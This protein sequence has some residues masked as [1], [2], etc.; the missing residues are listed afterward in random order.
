MEKATAK[1]NVI[2]LKKIRS[3]LA[4]TRKTAEKAL[5][6]AKRVEHATLLA[7]KQIS[8]LKQKAC[9]EV[10]K[11]EAKLATAE[12]N[13]AT[14]EL[15]LQKARK[16]CQKAETTLASAR[17]DLN[18]RAKAVA[19]AAHTAQRLEAKHTTQN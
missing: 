7:D 11:L 5:V 15:E 4:T 1:M 17:L 19:L 14:I 2:Q 13:K 8:K 16:A 6:K 3:R 12:K 18:K 9:G 10:K